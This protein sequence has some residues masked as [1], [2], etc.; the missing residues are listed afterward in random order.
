M[1]KIKIFDIEL[2]FEDVYDMEN[3]LELFWEDGWIPVKVQYINNKL[4]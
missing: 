1:Y 2:M 4:K 3:W